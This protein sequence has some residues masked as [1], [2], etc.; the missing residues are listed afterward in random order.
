MARTFRI[1]YKQLGDGF[2]RR[3]AQ[4]DG[5]RNGNYVWR[6]RFVF[7]M[8]RLDFAHLDGKWNGKHVWREHFVFGMKSLGLDLGA[9]FS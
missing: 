6:E 9:R 5:K 1:R 8:Q 4:L 7:G 2:R 3:F